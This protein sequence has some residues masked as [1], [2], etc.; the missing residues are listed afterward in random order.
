MRRAKRL[1]ILRWVARPV[2]GLASSIT[3]EHRLGPLRCFTGTDV[4]QITQLDQDPPRGPGMVAAM[5]ETWSIDAPD[6]WCGPMQ[7]LVDDRWRWVARPSWPIACDQACQ[8]L[9]REI[10][11]TEDP[12]QEAWRSLF[13]RSEGTQA[14]TFPRLAM[15][16]GHYAWID[17]ATGRRHY[18]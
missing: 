6:V 18:R 17:V 16:G 7:Q 1:F 14:L 10:S 5:N 3:Q 13:N 11:G 4:Y 2:Y 8:Q 15:D 12:E 9:I